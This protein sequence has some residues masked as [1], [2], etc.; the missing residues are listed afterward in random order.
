MT[1]Q[2]DNVNYKDNR[3]FELWIELDFGVY[4]MAR[5]I[6]LYYFLKIFYQILFEQYDYFL[7]N[8]YL[9]CLKMNKIIDFCGFLLSW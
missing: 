7:R 3:S 1:K 6:L 9:I 8:H 4:S 2:I 5:L